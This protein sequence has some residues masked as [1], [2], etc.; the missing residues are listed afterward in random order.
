MSENDDM[1]QAV[2]YAEIILEGQLSE[3]SFLPE[4]E[5]AVRDYEL[6]IYGTDEAT[7]WGWREYR[8][9]LPGT[10]HRV[11]VPYSDNFGTLVEHDGDLK[12]VVEGEVFCPD[13][14]LCGTRLE[15][16]I[17]EPQKVGTER[18]VRRWNEIVRATSTKPMRES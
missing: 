8:P 12:L 15:V 17:A 14:D 2:A 7:R 9:E 5:R 13:D 11:A 6:A 16:R 18:A 1:N 10:R 3:P 4:L